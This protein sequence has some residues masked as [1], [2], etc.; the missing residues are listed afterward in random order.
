MV[1][2]GGGNRQYGGSGASGVT[3]SATMLTIGVKLLNGVTSA[4]HCHKM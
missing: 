2:W 3:F 4:N 1:Q